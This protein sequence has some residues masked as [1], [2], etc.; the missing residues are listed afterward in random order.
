MGSLRRVENDAV[1]AVWT[2]PHGFN[3]IYWCFIV[4]APFVST[5]KHDKVASYRSC[6]HCEW[7]E[8]V[9]GDSCWG[10]SHG[11]VCHV[12]KPYRSGELVDDEA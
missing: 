8:E 11:F 1:F 7:V 2:I 9:V 10:E 12:Q 6:P 5:Y 3:D 4:S